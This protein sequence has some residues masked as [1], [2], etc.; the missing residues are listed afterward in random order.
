MSSPAWIPPAADVVIVNWNTGRHLRDCLRAVGR[1]DRSELRVAQIVVV[2]NASSD[3]SLSGLDTAGIP[4]QVVRNTA[5]RGFA[6]ACNQGAARC[7]SALILFLNPDTEPYPDALRAVG[8]FLRSP[9]ADTIGICGGRMVDEHGR[10]GI[11]CS[12]FPSLRI[13]VG[14]T[15]GLDRLLPS[16]F[17]PHHLR[18]AETTASRRV[19][20]V[21]GAF[22]LVRRSLF[23]ELGGFDE[24]YF[25]YFEETDLALRALQNG[26]GSYYVQQARVHHI[27][28]V[29]SSQLG[30]ERLRLSLC[31]RCL[32]AF[33][34]WPPGR[35]WSLVALTLTVEPAARLTR[36]ALRRS[37]TEFRDTLSGYWGFLHW[38]LEQGLP[39][40]HRHR[41]PASSTGSVGDG[42]D[43]PLA[44]LPDPGCRP[45]HGAASP[46]VSD[47]GVRGSPGARHQW[48]TDG[49]PPAP[50]GR[51]GT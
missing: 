8:R 7:G 4:L 38:L 25:L 13:F 23:T 2:D 32:Y 37:P 24:R 26:W 33:R 50:G 44:P 10:P 15:T 18:P 49:V 29:S 3:D 47:T 17:P 31:S 41:P 22:F 5:N 9:A 20:Q 11:S 35:A 48:A 40:G 43:R 34:H 36:A 19:D 21:I 6:A 42:S 14:K 12:R 39:H 16:V 28:G 46:P 51:R 27:G 30:G 45:R 1:A